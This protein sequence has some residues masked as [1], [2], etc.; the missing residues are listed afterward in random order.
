MALRRCWA[1]T[2]AGMALDTIEGGGECESILRFYIVE[3]MKLCRAFRQDNISR[4]AFF[5]AVQFS[6]TCFV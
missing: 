1:G 4:N 6:N 5:R 3:T 2:I